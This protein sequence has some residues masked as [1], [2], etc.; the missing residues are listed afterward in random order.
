MFSDPIPNKI[1]LY[2]MVCIN[3]LMSHFAVY[4]NVHLKLIKSV[5]FLQCLKAIRQPTMCVLKIGAERRCWVRDAWD[6][7]PSATHP[8][9]STNRLH[10]TG[11]KCD[12]ELL[13]HTP[14]HIRTSERWENSADFS[15]VRGKDAHRAPKWRSPKTFALTRC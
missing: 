14:D 15:F 6:S 7:P 8:D 4:C 9:V 11:I 2:H 12:S 13:S 5:I 3:P 1:L 10:R